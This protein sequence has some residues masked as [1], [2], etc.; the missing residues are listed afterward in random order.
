MLS[1]PNKSLQIVVPNQMIATNMAHAGVETISSRAGNSATEFA[2][3]M[4]VLSGYRDYVVRE[5]SVGSVDEFSI[6]QRPFIIIV[7]FQLL[8]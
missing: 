8:V 4:V 7:L 6:I 1:D 5:V 3:R 2:G